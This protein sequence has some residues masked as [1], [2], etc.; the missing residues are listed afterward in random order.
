MKEIGVRGGGGEGWSYA[1]G[2]PCP[3]AQFEPSSTIIST[4]SG[5]GGGGGGYERGG[6]QP[7][8]VES[9]DEGA[10]WGSESDCIVWSGSLSAW[11]RLSVE[12]LFGEF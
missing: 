3:N 7:P 5:G 11:S 8:P 4:T 10:L 9:W 12:F 2:R 6:E 1:T